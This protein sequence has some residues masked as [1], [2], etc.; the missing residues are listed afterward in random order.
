MKLIVLRP[1]L[2]IV[3]AILTMTSIAPPTHAA[4]IWA[5]SRVKSVYPLADGSVVIALME[6]PPTCTNAANPK[7]LHILVGQN[8]VTADGLK[9]ML[10]TALTAFA[11]DAQVQVNFDDANSACYVNRIALAR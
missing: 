2:T 9:N 10:A 1:M 6:N 7:H 8:G 5:I 11:M 4:A 3:A